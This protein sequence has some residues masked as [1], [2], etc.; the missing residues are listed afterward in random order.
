MRNEKARTLH[1]SAQL[2]LDAGASANGGWMFRVLNGRGV[3]ATSHAARRAIEVLSAA[4]PSTRCLDEICAELSVS[5]PEIGAAGQ[6][7][8]LNV[9][10]QLIVY[11]L[12]LPSSVPVRAGKATAERPVAWPIAR[13]DAAAG[14]KTTTNL[15]H[16]TV[17]LDIITFELLPHLDGSHTR[18]MLAERLMNTIRSGRINMQDPTTN[19]PL[20]GKDL[21]ASVAAHV[22]LAIGRLAAA[23]LLEPEPG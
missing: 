1:V 11:G 14:W 5:D 15:R 7:D 10:F 22:D 4:F 20:T 18:P 3:T 12:G 6:A 23:A 21:E 2:A 9:M 19:Q 17:P 13:A 16:E 8:I